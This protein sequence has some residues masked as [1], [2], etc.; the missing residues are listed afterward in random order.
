MS[1]FIRFE[2]MYANPDLEL[3]F[4]FT[5]TLTLMLSLNLVCSGRYSKPP[6][7]AVMFSCQGRGSN[8]FGEADPDHDSST[9][10]SA[11]PVPTAGWFGNGEIGPLGAVLPQR[12]Q[13]EVK[14]YMHGYTSVFAM[15]YDTS[16][17]P[18]GDRESDEEG[19]NASDEVR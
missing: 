1:L 5:F 7:C 10:A 15:I 16:D 14:T 2:R 13:A 18:D 17:D 4:N 19:E 12:G 8:L 11:V 3:K 6:L 9:F